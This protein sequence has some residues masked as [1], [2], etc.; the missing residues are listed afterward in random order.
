[1]TVGHHTGKVNLGKVGHQ[2]DRIILGMI[3]LSED[4]DS[5]GLQD[6]SQVG[7]SSDKKDPINPEE[8]NHSKDLNLGMKDLFKGKHSSGMKHSGT[9]ISKGLME[10]AEKVDK[11]KIGTTEIH[12]MVGTIQISKEKM[13]DSS[14]EMIKE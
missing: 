5:L 1:M 13:V 7:T 9:R 11:T 8:M 2:T 3:G 4:P 14:K 6:N 12:K 10:E